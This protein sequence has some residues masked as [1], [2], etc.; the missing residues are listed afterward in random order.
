MNNEIT[1]NVKLL[2]DSGKL[3]VHG[4]ATKMLFTYNKENLK[5][6]TLKS[7]EWDYYL[8]YNKDFAVSF[9]VANNGYMGILGAA[10]IDF[11]NKTTK[12]TN[13]LKWFPNNKIKMPT[14]STEGNVLFSNSRVQFS[15]ENKKDKR[16][17]KVVFLSFEKDDTLTAVIELKNKPADSMVIATPFQKEHQFYLNQKTVGYIASGMV[18][19]GNREFVFDETSSRAILDFGRGVWPYKTT[20]VWSSACGKVSEDE[21]AFNFGG[22]FGNTENATENMLF[23][24]GKATKLDKINFEIPKNEKGKL[25]FMETWKIT[26]NL[27]TV[28]LTFTPIVN[29]H[30]F[31]TAL[32]ISSN[33]NQVFGTFNGTLKFGSKIIKLENFLGFAEKVDNKW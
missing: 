16:I 24:N 15:F 25:N 9:T 11:K 32:I 28:N 33:Q 18:T 23:Y 27:N 19:I 20:W 3:A 5:T 8:I 6:G 14:S 22:G 7:K 29:R 12:T 2:D 1:E 10:F 13:V 31:S 21:I 4:Y 17:L 26:D 30:S